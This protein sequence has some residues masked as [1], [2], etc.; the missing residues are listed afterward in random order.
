MIRPHFNVVINIHALNTLRAFGLDHD[1]EFLARKDGPV[2]MGL[3]RRAEEWTGGMGS[4]QRYL[5]TMGREL[6]VGKDRELL[7][8]ARAA[9]EE[10]RLSR[11]AARAAAGGAPASQQKRA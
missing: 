11:A 3:E 2:A 6:L 8:D 5:D 7:A 10:Q 1:A 4:L 9:C